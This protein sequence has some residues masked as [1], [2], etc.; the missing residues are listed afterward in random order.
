MAATTNSARLA[1]FALVLALG[2]SACHF[3]EQKEQVD[4]VVAVTVAQV[5]RRDVAE[6]VTAI[7]TV[8]AKAE[9][10][11]SPKVSAP[12]AEM[13]IL[14]N[15]YVTAGETIAVLESRDLR[16]A[17]SEADA[18]VREADAALRQ[19]AGGTNPEADAQTLKALRD[20]EAKLRNAEALVARRQ[21]LFDKGGIP[22]KELEDAQ[23]QLSQAQNDFTLAQREVSL[24]RSNLDPTNTE[25]AASRLQQARNRAANAHAQVDYAIV[26]S[27]ISG[28]VTEQFHQKGEFAAAGDKLVTVAD[29][30]QVIVK[31]QFPDTKVE[32]IEGG[33]NA[34]L[35]PST[36]QEEPIF[37]TVQLVSRDVDPASRTVEIWVGVVNEDNLLRPGEFAKVT[38]VTREAVGAIAVPP[39]AV[40]FD[41]P[42]GDTGKVMVVDELSVAHEVEVT[43][44]V[45][46]EDAYEIVE[47]LT[48]G[49]TVIV[50]GNYALPDGTKVRAVDAAEEAGEEKA[51]D[52]P[53]AEETP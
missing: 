21:F 6:R 28:V 22:K 53:G 29:I 31:A 17:A 30:G 35:E 46:G 32:G 8:T 26:R 42:T 38:I 48:G 23:L 10:T 11:I 14:K 36:G 45:R 1:A 41:D 25:I 2:A 27:P 3:G 15:R 37:G 24:A 39:S 47:G 33:A 13:A 20:A 51:D 34:Q 7:G 9:A 5:E 12:I 44:G 19:M 43:V 16:A 50:E 18:A 49:E 52:E 4:A 40:T